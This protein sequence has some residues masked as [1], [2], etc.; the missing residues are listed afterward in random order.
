[1]FPRRL[2]R[3]AVAKRQRQRRRRDALEGLGDA[4]ESHG[5]RGFVFGPDQVAG[6]ERFD[7]AQTFLGVNE[8]ARNG[9]E[10]AQK[11]GFVGD[12]TLQSG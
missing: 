2:D 1:M 7:G 12:T 5:A 11:I 3:L 8:C 6:I 10:L 4:L 9:T